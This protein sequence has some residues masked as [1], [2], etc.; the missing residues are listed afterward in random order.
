MFCYVFSVNTWIDLSV[1]SDA[2]SVHNVLETGGELV[3]LVV[4]RWSLFGLHSVQ[5]G[6]NC[7]ATPF[8]H[9]KNMIKL[10]LLPL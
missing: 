6:G 9:K 8:L 5:D 2:V 3:G 10:T 4:S 1:R 7:G